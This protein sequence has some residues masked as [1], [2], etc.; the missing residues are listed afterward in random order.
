M[1]GL[2]VQVRGRAAI[3]FRTR[4]RDS[5][6]GSYRPTAIVRP[7]PATPMRTPSVRLAFLLGTL[8]LLATSARAQAITGRVISSTGAGVAGVNIDGFDSGGNEL[9]LLNDGTDAAGNFATTVVDGPGVY[10]FVFYPPAPPTTTHLVGTRTNVVVVTTTNLGNVALG[11]GVLLSGR[12]VRGASI[13][14]ANVTLEVLD[15][16]TQLPITQIQ[17]KTNAFG[18]F[19]LAVPEQPIELRLDPS[20][21]A[22]VLAAR[23]FE[24]TPAGTLAMGDLKLPTGAIVT[25]H[26]QRTN[27]TAVSGAD[28]DFRKNGNANDSFVYN[29]NTNAAGNFSVILPLGTYEVT[30]CPKP[31]DLLATK[32]VTNFVVAGNTALPTQVVVAGVEL[33]GTVLSASG[34]PAQGVDVDVLNA[35]TGVPIPLCNDNTDANGDYSVI[36]PAGTY[37]VRFQRP[38]SGGSVG[39]DLHDNVVVS[40]TT[41]L[42]GQLPAHGGAN[43]YG[44]PIGDAGSR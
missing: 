42:D 31:A 19:N 41:L 23:R 21:S 17:T 37:D 36:V 39:A 33:H 3:G 25:G 24:R 15:A 29:D 27:A 26:V 20:S 13:P 5:V 11:A 6:A 44:G 10:T 34:Q 22:F 43:S 2:S 7:P 38:S 30:V 35:T 9:D 16:A 14:V 8:L 12:A 18:N 28:L 40:G 4:S 32:V 1:T